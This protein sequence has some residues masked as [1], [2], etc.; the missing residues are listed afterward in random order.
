MKQLYLILTLLFLACGSLSAQEVLVGDAP[1]TQPFEG[2]IRYSVSATVKSVSVN[3]GYLP[4]T[5][6]LTVSH[7]WV[8]IQYK[9]GL[10][11][12]MMSR[13][14]WNAEQGETQVIYAPGKLYHTTPESY[15]PD[16]G[17]VKKLGQKEK[18]AGIECEKYQI[19]YA[20]NPGKDVVWVSPTL[21]FPRSE[22]DTALVYRPVFIH[23]QLPGLPLKVVRTEG[24]TITTITAREI[25][26]GKPDPDFF[27]VPK[28][29]GYR[30]FNPRS[31]D[32]FPLLKDREAK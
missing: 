5:L 24:N 7:P 4:D 26:P 14:R 13:I 18:I 28:N 23:P 11:D 27:E 6:I 21:T 9:G 25:V 16:P 29:W 22:A 32:R 17:T 30:I 10:A 12:S 1:G 15:K 19:T 8:Q 2:H 31:T 3:E 20:G